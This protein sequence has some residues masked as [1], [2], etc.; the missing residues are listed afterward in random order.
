MSKTVGGLTTLFVYDE[1]GHLLGEYDGAGNLIQETVWLEDL[2][3]ATLRPTGAQGNPTPINVYYVH[4][5]HLGSPRAVTR[6]SDN[7]LMWQWDNLDPF[8]ANAAT[9]NPGGQGVFKYGLRFPGQYYDAEAGT[10]YNYYRDYDPTI[11]RYEQSDP[12]GLRAGPNTYAYVAAN[13]LR[14]TD[15]RG[16]LSFPRR[17]PFQS[18]QKPDW[19]PDG[20]GCGDAST[21]WI[22]PDTIFIHACEKHDQCYKTCGVSKAG[23]DFQFLIDMLAACAQNPGF[24]NCPV[25]AGI[26]YG[27]VFAGG[28]SAFADAQKLKCGICATQ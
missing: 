22:I 7:V 5:D 15:P 9:E 6:P 19:W 24:M 18:I 4:A 27:A 25:L 8:G 1:Q 28:T 17:P 3:V 14:F 26:Y 23:C 13:P 20:S 10:N 2:P 21:D 16:L 11:G 12:L